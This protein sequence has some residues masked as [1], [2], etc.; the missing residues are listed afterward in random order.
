MSSFFGL[1]DAASA[2][3]KPI[4]AT[5]DD[6]AVISAKAA[7]KTS[8]IVVDDVATA[9]SFT[10]GFK[11]ER[12]I[13]IVWKIAKASLF[14]KIVILMPIVLALSFFAPW[15]IDPLLLIGAFYLSYE[16]IVKIKEL[17]SKANRIE[18]KSED[19]A[20][21]SAVTLDFILSFEIML[22]ALS[23]ITEEKIGM[24]VAA[25]FSVSVLI[26]SIVYGLVLVIVR[27]DE[28]G[29]WLQKKRYVGIF[30][31]AIIGVMPYLLKV[32]SILGIVFM[33]SI[34]SHLCVECLHNL[35][36]DYL[37]NAMKSLKNFLDTYPYMIVD[38]SLNVPFGLLIGLVI[39]LNK[40]IA[41]KFVK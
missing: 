41:L 34:G 21:K 8:K 26:T 13:P 23:T 31:H 40:K 32:L 27:A 14:N 25:L 28:V 6:V 30:G 36:F 16:A 4:L 9:P 2:I 38:L 5:A 39:Y 12:E 7:S 15:A 19:Q 10:L 33:A 3:A 17:F 1:L 37:Y 35:G 18:Q 11:S 24:Q 20:V 29:L 22:I